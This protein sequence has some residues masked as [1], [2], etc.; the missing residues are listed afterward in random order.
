MSRETGLADVL[1]VREVVSP[2][3]GIVQ[4]YYE[5][6]KSLGTSSEKC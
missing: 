5:N 3:V 4:E 6:L 2:S 1:H